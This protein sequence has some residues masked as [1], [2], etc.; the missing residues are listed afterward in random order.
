MK[1]HC[2]R[3]AEELKALEQAKISGLNRITSLRTVFKALALSFD[4]YNKDVME[5]LSQKDKV[6]IGEIVKDTTEAIEKC[7]GTMVE[8]RALT[9]KKL[10][11][12]SELDVLR[13]ELNSAITTIQCLQ[14]SFSSL[15]SRPLIE[16]NILTDAS[17]PQTYFHGNLST[18]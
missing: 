4:K 11:S 6:N 3:T 9:K 18:C 5:S 15:V 7:K 17:D 16:V 1:K 14:A 12:K 10:R 13:D 8:L 2:S